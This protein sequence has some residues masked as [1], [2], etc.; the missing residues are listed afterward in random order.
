MRRSLRLASSLL[1]LAVLAGCPVIDDEVTPRPGP[2]PT[3]GALRVLLTY[4]S[5]EL[6]KLPHTQVAIL[7][8]TE[9]RSY[10]NEKCVKDDGKPAFR[11]WDKDVDA[12][13]ELPV[14]KNELAKPRA[15]LPWLCIDNGK[16][17]YSGPAPV[18]VE[19]A[20]ELFKKYGG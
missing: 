14:F 11:F 13:R 5:G 2:T 17:W 1:L 3:P 10:L 7:S 15:S 18:S 9:I 19:A 20:M 6:S 4:E 12:S 8:S 16:D